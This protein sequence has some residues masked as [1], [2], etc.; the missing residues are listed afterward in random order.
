VTD[1]IMRRQQPVQPQA[2]T[3]RLE[4]ADDPDRPAK[5][6]SNASAQRRDERQQRVAISATWPGK[7]FKSLDRFFV[8]LGMAR[9]RTEMRKAQFLQQSADRHLVEIDAEALL[10]DARKSRQSPESASMKLGIRRFP[11]RSR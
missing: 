10:D 5:A 8:L 1:D 9:A 4:A 6:A 11:R 3:S 7:F 2:V